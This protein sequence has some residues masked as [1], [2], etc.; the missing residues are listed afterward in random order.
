MLKWKGGQDNGDEDKD[1]NEDRLSTEDVV[2]TDKEG[3]STDFERVST[4]FEK[5]ILRQPIVYM[6]LMK[7]WLENSTEWEAEEERTIIAEEKAT[8]EALIKNI[9]DIKAEIEGRHNSC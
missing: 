5:V 3:V 2:S 4:D 6:R 7:K 9:D 1:L 8:N